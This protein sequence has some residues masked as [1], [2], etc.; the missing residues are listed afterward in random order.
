MRVTGM[1]VQ[2]LTTA[3]ISST[4]TSSLIILLSACTWCSSSLALASWSS[5]SLDAAV[6]DLGHFA[7]VALALGLRGLVLQFLDLV[8]GAVDAS[9]PSRARFPAG[10]QHI[11]LA[12]QFGQFLVQFGE[13]GLGRSRA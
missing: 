4:S 2:R 10:L 13:L 12:A 9:P 6:A 8:L 1:P 5:V 11:A 3:A 7:V